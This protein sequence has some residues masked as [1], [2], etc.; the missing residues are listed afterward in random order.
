MVK[1]SKKLVL[2]YNPDFW[3][4]V[5][6]G[7]VQVTQQ[8]LLDEWNRGVLLSYYDED[9]DQSMREP[10]A[11]F[12]VGTPRLVVW[13]WFDQQFTHGLI[14]TVFAADLKLTDAQMQERYDKIM[15]LPDGM[16]KK[17]GLYF[18]QDLAVRWKLAHGRRS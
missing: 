12:V 17:L 16:A 3:L 18:F 14:M 6:K 11:G 1:R 4:A 13:Y 10:W 8:Q 15:R 2:T 9:P 5:H 7:D